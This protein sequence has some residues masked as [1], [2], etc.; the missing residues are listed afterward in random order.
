MDLMWP[1]FYPVCMNLIMAFVFGI[2]LIYPPTIIER[3]ARRRE[4]D[5]DER[6]VAYTRQVTK[7]WFGFCLINGMISLFT[8]VS[9]N[10]DLWTLYNGVISYGLMGILFVGEYCVRYHL[11]RQS[12]F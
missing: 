10:I 6:G 11:R 1:L 4:P 8:A 12:R 2:S 7:V 5:L 3:I 9:G